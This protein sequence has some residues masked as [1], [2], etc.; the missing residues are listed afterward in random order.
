MQPEQVPPAATPP[1]VAAAPTNT[2]EW[3]SSVNQAYRNT[4][5]REISRVL[6]ALE[7]GASAASKLRL[8]M[9]FED[10]VFKSSVSLADYTKKLTKRLKKLQRNYVPPIAAPQVAASKES[11]LKELRLTYGD[12]LQYILK[13]ADTAVEEYRK[14]HGEEKAVQL[15]QHTDGVYHWAQDL[16]LLSAGRGNSSSA[17]VTMSSERLEKLKRDL[18]RR[19]ENIRSHVVKLADPDTFMAETL[20]KREL[21]FWSADNTRPSRILAE[22]TRRRYEQLYHQQ[23]NTPDKPSSLQADKLLTE[24]MTA[25]QKTVPLPT[26]QSRNTSDLS[27]L[28]SEERAALIHL[29]KMRSASTVLVAYMALPDKTGVSNVVTKAHIIARDG[30]DFCAKVMKV[31][32]ERTQEPVVTLEDAWMKPLVVL[33]SVVVE[34]NTK[35]DETALEP[36]TRK[37]QRTTNRPIVRSRLLLTANR[38]TP[39]NLLPALRRKRARLVRPPPRGEGSHLILEFGDAFQMTIYFVPLLVT[40]RAVAV[41]VTNK[42]DNDNTKE[43]KSRPDEEDV[44]AC[45]SWVPLHHGLTDRQDLSVW[46]A[47][48]DY[49]TLGSVVEERLRDASV[50]ATAVL[51]QCF[52]PA[53]NA[54]TDFE[55]EILEATALLEFLQV[56]RTTY[57]PD[58]QD[59]DS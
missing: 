54:T 1:A 41:V 57:M 49:A 42:D 27:S 18:E 56:A 52:A 29:E 58:W 39:S 6:A 2:T 32:R 30:I 23:F 45:A 47:K 36:A 15:K 8:A 10:A 17:N 55:T 28:Q 34:N 13:H 33:P 14:R 5:V 16:G 37:R 9:Q 25:A 40:L 4:Q 7:P 26:K 43:V 3:R 12:A 11:V 48:G 59:D 21:E 35:E 53:Q 46:G 31:H 22:C 44:P 50:H 24:A 19:T 51:R 38:K 20:A